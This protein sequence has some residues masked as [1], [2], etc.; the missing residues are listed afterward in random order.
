MKKTLMLLL[1]LVPLGLWAATDY[2]A[3]VYGRDYQLLNGKWAA[4]VDLYDAGGKMEIYKNKKAE[5]PEEFYEYSFEGGL[6][7]NVPGDWNS[8]SPELKYYEGTVWYA[9][10]FDA[11]PAEGKR[12]FLYFAGVSYLCNIYLN[13]EK[14]G[15]HEG[16]FTPFQIEVTDKLKSGDN[17]LVLEVNNRRQK[18]AIPAMSFDWWNYGGITSATTSSALTNTAQ[19]LSI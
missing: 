10:H 6:R 2:I 3:N 1:A 13:G 4:I 19:T 7:L 12:R 14:V 17:L 8:Q 16:S 5:K 15:S 11:Q 18:D 9:R